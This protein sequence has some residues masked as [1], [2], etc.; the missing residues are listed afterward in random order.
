MRKKL[1]DSKKDLADALQKE[2]EGRTMGFDD[3]HWMKDFDKEREM[4]LIQ[5]EPSGEE[6][7]YREPLK[8]YDIVRN[9]SAGQLL[10]GQFLYNNLQTSS[11][12]RQQLIEVDD[13]IKLMAPGINETME[14]LEI[15]DR[16]QAETFDS[17]LDQSGESFAMAIYAGFSKFIHIDGQASG[18]QTDTLQSKKSSDVQESFVKITQILFVPTASFTLSNQTQ[19]VYL[20]KCALDALK[21]LNRRFIEGSSFNRHC[22]LFFNEFGSHFYTGVCHFGGR[23]K[24]AV[25]STT[26]STKNLK[27]SY[28]SAKSALSGSIGGGYL[29]FGGEI[30][31]ASEKNKK[32]VT[33]TRT[34][35][36]S[37][38]VE[39]KLEKSGG[40]QEN[41]EIRF[42]K[43][44][45]A[46][47]NSTWVVI[48][49]E[50][51]QKCYE[52]VWTLLKNHEHDFPDSE[53]FGKAIWKV[54]NTKYSKNEAMKWSKPQLFPD[55]N[56]E[57]DQY[58][59]DEETVSIN[60]HIE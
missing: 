6:I 19:S 23:Y 56:S 48:D 58:S 53:N 55:C 40:P 4:R 11:T 46:E 3:K 59:D 33:E 54:W 24:W 27:E 51:S 13:N 42:W 32:S 5:K 16:K 52:G 57:S 7:I 30:K 17:V 22:N 20:S 60:Y 12:Y 18:S 1:P 14:V 39:K 45:L 50:I 37:I 44:G 25:T 9:I 47:Y 21:L 10:R 28:E 2:A 38:K 8:D 36:E 15:Y 26:N 35:S 31:G 49:K 43:K 41:D 29:W 34:F